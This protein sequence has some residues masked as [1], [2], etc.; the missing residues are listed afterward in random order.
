ME[1]RVGQDGAA[2]QAGAR[3]ADARRN[4]TRILTAAREV[5]AEQGASASTEAVAARAGVAIGT[6][7]RH[8]PTKP[9]LLSAV[10][11][12]AWDQLVVRVDSLVDGSDDSVALFEF[13]LSAMSSCVENS[14]AFAKLAE[15]GTRVHVGDALSRLGP[16]VD[17]LL[18][19]AQAVGAVRGDLRSDELL[20]LLGALCQEAMTSAWGE[21]VRRRALTI[22]FE[23][24]DA[25]P[26]PEPQAEERR[27]GGRARP[28]R[29]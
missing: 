28:R 26:K 27:P 21:P 8:F 7:F 20:A 16:R 24:I 1:P 19:R 10:V 14:A 6:V 22:V 15:S 25:G 18:Q 13:C 23:G 4:R 9:D 29:S 17:V 12:D 5:F 3:R 11:M 2:G